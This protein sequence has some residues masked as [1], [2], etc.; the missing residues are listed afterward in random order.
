MVKIAVGSDHAA[1]KFKEEIKQYLLDKGLT[2]KDY[3]TFSEERSDYSDYAIKVGEAVAANECDYGI[4]FCGTGVGMSIAANKVKGIR[5]VVCSEPYSAKLAK[6]HN[7]SNVLALGAR[8]IGIELAK[9]IVDTWLSSEFE[10]GRHALRVNKITD[11]EN[12]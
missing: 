10:G 12:R 8:V 7:N 6:Q 1:F 2:V 11:Y 5:A 9:M 3:G 4:L